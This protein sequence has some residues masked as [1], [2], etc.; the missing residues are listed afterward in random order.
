LKH[1]QSIHPQVLAPLVDCG[2]EIGDALPHPAPTARAR[3][4][5][6]SKLHPENSA[7][8]SLATDTVRRCIAKQNAGRAI[9]PS[10]ANDKTRRRSPRFVFI[11]A[12][13]NCWRLPAQDPPRSACS[14]VNAPH[15]APTNTES[16]LHEG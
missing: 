7:G 6:R 12:V 14:I 13:M 10:I 9:R 2:C 15:E 3:R 11:P 1:I 8:P 4:S 5:V 16:G